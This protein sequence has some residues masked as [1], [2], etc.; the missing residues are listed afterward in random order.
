M[1]PLVRQ[2]GT[3]LR[4]PQAD[5][6]LSEFAPPSC[7]QVDSLV[8]RSPFRPRL[9]SEQLRRS[10]KSVFL[11][12][13]TI[14]QQA[15]A[16]CIL[17]RPRMSNTRIAKPLREL[18]RSSST[19]ATPHKTACLYQQ[20]QL[21]PC[22]VSQRHG[23]MPNTLSASQLCSGW[24]ITRVLATAV[25]APLLPNPN[26]EMWARKR[27]F[28]TFPSFILFLPFL[29]WWGDVWPSVSSLCAQ[30]EVSDVGDDVCACASCSLVPIT[31]HCLG[32]V[33][34]CTVLG[35][36]VGPLIASSA[37]APFV[38]QLGPFR[39][40][41]VGF[42]LRHGVHLRLPSNVSGSAARS[43]AT[44]QRAAFAQRCT[45]SPHARCPRAQP[46][47]KKR[48]RLPAPTGSRPAARPKALPA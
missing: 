46:R 7:G 22:L 15:Y 39:F 2:A 35:Q 5:N 31:K 33:L 3:G 32:R 40:G 4:F 19:S 16:S 44:R 6:C 25:A 23:R 38:I 34:T 26:Q 36:S 10:K 27:R 41:Q 20:M 37:E 8:F 28:H 43:L 13:P 14:R 21:R 1:F 9:R 11:G 42:A 18:G 17:L 47:N 45:T 12:V 29:R 48:R 30:D 24:T